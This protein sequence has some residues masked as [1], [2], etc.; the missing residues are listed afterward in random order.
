MKNG[1]YCIVVGGSNIFTNFVHYTSPFSIYAYDI[2]K[3]NSFGNR[4]NNLFPKYVEDFEIYG[5]KIY[6]P[7]TGKIAYLKKDIT[8]NLPFEV[9][10]KENS[11]NFVIIS[12]GN[13]FITLAHLRP[14]T[15]VVHQND[16][17]S[18]GDYI[19]EVGNTGKSIEPHLHIEVHEQ[20]NNQSFPVSIMF[21]NKF[22]TYNDIIKR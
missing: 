21:D 22:Y 7:C 10:T 18:A 19:G 6:S 5:E 16:S 4:A 17:I 11:G 1:K 9:N 14:N 15:I 3:I 13:K 8:D 12:T 2:V 20:K